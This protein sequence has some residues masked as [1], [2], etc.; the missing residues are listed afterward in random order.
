MKLCLLDTNKETDC[1]SSHEQ[2]KY[3][4]LTKKIEKRKKML[5]RRNVEYIALVIFLQS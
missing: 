5:K 4:G 2:Y 1:L 3:L